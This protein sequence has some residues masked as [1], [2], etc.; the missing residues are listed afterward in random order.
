MNNAESPIA[1]SIV[2]MAKQ[3]FIVVVANKLVGVVC[4][5]KFLWG[6]QRFD[7]K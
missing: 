6:K 2:S 4:F 3:S 1:M 7:T 5:S